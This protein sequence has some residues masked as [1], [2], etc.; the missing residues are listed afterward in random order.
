MSTTDG[1]SSDG[2]DEVATAL[3]PE[4]QMLRGPGGV[5]VENAHACEKLR[6]IALATADAEEFPPKHYQWLVGEFI[7]AA[8]TFDPGTYRW[9]ACDLF[10]LS[11]EKPQEL[12]CLMGWRKIKDLQKI[13]VRE[14]I[15]AR[16]L[17]VK[18]RRVRYLKGEILRDCAAG[19]ASF[20][21]AESRARDSWRQA[22]RNKL[23]SLE[24]SLT[25]P[26]TPP[27]AITPLTG[28]GHVLA[29]SAENRRSLRAR[30]VQDEVRRYIV[31]EDIV[32]QL[33][34]RE[35]P[36][37]IPICGGAGAGKTVIA[38][39]IYDALLARQ[40]KSAIVIP[41][42]FLNG[43]PLTAD[44]FDLAFGEMVGAAA[45][46]IN[47][48]KTLSENSARPV[49]V[50]IDTVDNVINLATYRGII[51]L[52]RRILQA[53]ASVVFTSRSHEYKNWIEPHCDQFTP[54]PPAAVK[55]PSLG[56]NEAARLVAGFLALHPPEITLDEV[57]FTE[58]I[59]AKAQAR[60]PMQRIVTNPYHLLM[61]CE[62]FAPRGG[63]PPDLTTTRLCTLY[64]D[65]KINT[66]RKYP[67]DQTVSKAK[68]RL[69][70]KVAG[71]LWTRSRQH[72]ALKL[73]QSWF[74]QNAE[75]DEALQDL[76]SE[77]V[78]IRTSL[79]SMIVE[80]NHQSLAEYFIAIYLRD[81]DTDALVQLLV[82]LKDAPE[83]RWFTWQ[84]VRHALATALYDDDV[85]SLLGQMNL[86]EAY[87]YQTAA[88]GLVEQPFRGH[89]NKLSEYVRHYRSLFMLQVLYFAPDERLDEVYDLLKNVMLKGTAKN[90]SQAS[91]VAGRLATRVTEGAQQNTAHLAS[92]FDAIAKIRR[93]EA[94]LELSDPSF[95]DQ[96]IENLLR[97]TTEERISLPKE[98]L[99]RTHTLVSGATPVCFRSVIRAHLAG[100][101]EID[102]Q[103]RLLEKLLGYKFANKVRLEGC[104]L[105]AKSV[106]WDIATSDE[107]Q[108]RLQ[109]ER[110]ASTSTK[111]RMLGWDNVKPCDFLDSGGNNSEQL[112]ATALAYVANRTE[113]LRTPI[114]KLFTDLRDFK[115]ANRALI[116]LQEIIKA[117]GHQWLLA[118][119]KE[120]VADDDYEIS[121]RLSALV[122]VL[123]SEEA[124]VRHAW[125]AWFKPHV[126][127]ELYGTIDAYLQIAWDSPED[128]LFAIE[129]FKMLPAKRRKSVAANFS[130]LQLPGKAA[131]AAMLSQAA[132]FDMDD[133]LK[134][135]RM[136]ITG[137]RV[138]DGLIDMVASESR[139]ASAQAMT[140]WEQAAA[141]R[142]PWVT[143]EPLGRYAADQ[144]P[145]IRVGI[146]K[147]IAILVR[148]RIGDVDTAVEQ[149]IGAAI[150][151]GDESWGGVNEERTQLIQICH[152]Y[153]RENFGADDKALALIATY[154]N[155]AVA[156]VT[157]ESEI[158]RELLALIKT[159][160]Y[161]DDEPRRVLSATWILDM[162]DRVDAKRIREGEDFTRD[163]LNRLVQGKNL[164]LQTIVSKSKKWKAG[165]LEVAVDVIMKHDARRQHSPL[166]DA[167]L[168]ADKAEAARSRVVSYR[169]V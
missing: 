142:R 8:T 148:N 88:Q 104:E 39:Q 147:T 31:D 124:P 36:S 45:G 122:K 101:V 136:D 155:R 151:R 7:I 152:S 126:T 157:E 93:G 78:L 41:C 153:L 43:S 13:G 28:F 73:P 125:A 10:K 32:P 116:C 14:E 100:G 30:K 107:P 141:A 84:F 42:Q 162:L 44:E 61:L 112:R 56:K 134:V 89:L 40:I 17:F 167:L 51:A 103:R 159:A 70:Y 91:I 77:E 64:V 97:P 105:V 82:E 133:L 119:L 80:F 62:V 98:V 163:T 115:T 49:V 71:E 110:E 123:D 135:R 18:P 108:P 22:V 25:E 24:T 86:A 63:V 57:G 140:K 34:A 132:D 130:K 143:P 127:E 27:H 3:L 53:G 46:L 26:R 90:V 76:L 68:R 74:D 20:A 1:P 145:R 67:H 156:S 52:F 4:L 168:Q 11:Q 138:P 166:L 65:Q 118:Q 83:N 96:L 137:D 92:L 131:A 58:E 139:D 87:A 16:R 6:K 9:A 106:R 95:P 79:D 55:V 111:A 94:A 169:I 60:V 102:I 59:W 23:R 117:G 19:I 161:R 50:I 150:R 47:I 113:E 38:G 121:G 165:S 35:T 37:I 12:L 5:S 33:L 54:E 21:A 69:L 72:I 29:K 160:A 154:V 75:N 120:L 158:R 99:L 81:I 114:V 146:L 109:L 66:S 149:W 144:N 85:R 2:Q 15:A 164:S 128:L 48:T 129:K